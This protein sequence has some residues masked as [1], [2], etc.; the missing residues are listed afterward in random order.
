M[1]EF[2][3]VITSDGA[4]FG[5]ETEFVKDGI[6]EVTRAVAGEG[7]A[8]AVGS[9]RSRGEAEDE[10]AGAGVTKAGNGAGPVGLILI[11]AAPGFADAA[12]VGAKAGT[13]FAGDDGLLNLQESRGRK[14]RAGGWHCIP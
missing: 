5:G 4:G 10:D 13:A 12:A 7:T 8:G 1:A 2:E 11:G 14:L 6:H 9:V 3:A